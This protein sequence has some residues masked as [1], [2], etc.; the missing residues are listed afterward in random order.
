MTDSHSSTHLTAI[1][2]DLV[3]AYNAKD[4]A[5]VRELFAP[6][7]YFCHHNRNFEFRDRDELIAIMRHF[8]TEAVPDRRFHPAVRTIE[9]GNVVIREQTWG[10]EA[11]VDIPGMASKGEQLSLD[12]CSVFVFEGELIAEYH[13]YG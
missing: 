6:R 5:R 2:E 10:G 9:S 1:V 3:A 8:A 7:F 13:D 11:Q 12:L 4:F